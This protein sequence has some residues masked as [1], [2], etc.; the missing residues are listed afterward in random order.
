M[1]RTLKAFLEGCRAPA[2]LEYGEELIPLKAG[3][4][5]LE[6]RAGRVWIQAWHE[7]RSLSRRIVALEQQRP[8]MVDCEIQRFGG[9]TGKLSLLDL[10]RPQTGHRT[11]TGSRQSFAERFRRMLFRQFPGWKIV[12]LSSQMDLQRSFSPVFPRARLVKGN[13]QVAAMAC[14]QT[15]DEPG[16]LSFALLWFDYLAASARRNSM[17]TRLCLFLPEEAGTLTA[18]R[19]RWLEHSLLRPQLFRFNAHGSAGEV[20]PLDL[21]NLDTRV[22]GP[23][24]GR[25]RDGLPGGD[26]SLLESIVRRRL[27]VIDASL[28]E[29]PVLAQVLTFA[30]VNRDL[31]DLLAVDVRGR[32]ALIELK[33]SED[34][35]LPMQALDY[36]MRL[37]WHLERGELDRLFPGIALNR[38]APRMLLLAP[39]LCFHPTNATVIR[40][41]SP[42]IDVERVGIN[43]DWGRDL[44][45]LLRLRGAEMPQSHGSFDECSRFSAHQESHLESESGSGQAGIE[46]AASD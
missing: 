25:E 8:G 19:L 29:S 4:Y 7:N 18:H 34:L 17:S 30:G 11:L 5:C 16:L 33:V 37:M 13:Q 1:L 9:A 41:F 46:P 43:S 38:V 36:W 3:E 40:Y 39:A 26:E 44:R 10:E 21:G 45:V 23:A 15:S 31:I 24:N 2:V 20:D 27:Q 6:I 28:L 12:S 14:A 22:S 42:S 32:L 35:Q